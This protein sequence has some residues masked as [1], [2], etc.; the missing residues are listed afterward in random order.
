MPKSITVIVPSYNRAHLLPTTIPTYLQED[1]LELILV[2]DCSQDNTES[3]V[4]ELQKKY[5]QI[6][7]F[8]NA[9]NSKQAYS[10]NIGIEHAEGEYIYFGD[11]DSVITKDTIRLLLDT[12]KKHRA[13]ICGA[14]TLNAGN[15]F[16]LQSLNVFVEWMN[17]K[18]CAKTESEICNPV[19]LHFHFG[20]NYRNEI[21]VPMY[22]NACALVK[23]DLAKQTLFD[24]KY[25]GCA[26]REETDFFVQ[27]ALAGAKTIF[28]PKAVQV[29][30]PPK[31]VRL[32]G[33]RSGGFE[34]WKHSAQECN[35]YFLKKNW[36]AMQAKWGGIA[37][38]EEMQKKFETEIDQKESPYKNEPVKD[39]LKKLY[40]KFVIV[41]FY[42]RKKL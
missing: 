33:A 31:M 25:T 27:Q 1:V 23:A 3:V 7:Y 37:N 28:Q 20:L 5:P 19:N 15:Y 16:D 2:D 29:N 11:D 30:F 6:R 35:R 38:I 8:R 21:E 41:P 36:K 13:D 10:K 32:T 39:F 14:R 12:L 18:Y 42:G 4:R 22:A 24:P 34:E 40:F 9:V 17:H 26:Y